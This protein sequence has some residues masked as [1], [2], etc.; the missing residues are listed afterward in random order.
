MDAHKYTE[1]CFRTNQLR[2]GS[3]ARNKYNVGKSKYSKTSQLVHSIPLN[4]SIAA[5]FTPPLC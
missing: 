2:V 3:G 4:R 5:F 1:C